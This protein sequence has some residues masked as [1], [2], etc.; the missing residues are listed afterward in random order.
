MENLKEKF[1]ALLI[2]KFNVA[3]DEL[4]SEAKFTDLGADSLDM[5]ELIIE[6]EKTFSI[7]IPDEE[8]ETIIT[9]GDAEKYLKSHIN[10]L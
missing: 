1:N 3:V 8:A 9:I 7:T 10:I 4:K 5:V 2:E 6:F